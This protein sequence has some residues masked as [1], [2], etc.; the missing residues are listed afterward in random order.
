MKNYQVFVKSV[1]GGIS[2][3]GTDF[4]RDQAGLY[5]YKDDKV[6]AFFNNDDFRF[7]INTDENEVN[8]S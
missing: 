3:S 8:I 6:I 5:I 4:K 1:S 7:I 2:I